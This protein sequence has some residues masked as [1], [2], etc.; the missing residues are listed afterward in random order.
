MNR[1]TKLAKWLTD[2]ISNYSQYLK[3]N[4]GEAKTYNALISE[5]ETILVTQLSYS[6][7]HP[8]G[9]T[10]DECKDEVAKRHGYEDW[11]RAAHHINALKLM[12]EVCE[13][14]AQSKAGAS[15]LAKQG[16]RTNT[17]N[18]E[19]LKEIIDQLEFCNFKDEHGHEIKHNVAFIALKGIAN[20]SPLQP[21]SEFL[22]S[23]GW[24]DKDSG[25][26]DYNGLKAL[27]SRYAK[28][29]PAP[30]TKI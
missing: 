11:F 26:F 15:F 22:A 14:Y 25:H 16:G 5:L 17:Y 29:K 19:T 1:E 24:N 30:T 28:G 21:V 9:K 12:D 2:R 7:E 13:L 8:K 18:M 6:A 23:E 20:K 3:E 27:L 10:L 4:P